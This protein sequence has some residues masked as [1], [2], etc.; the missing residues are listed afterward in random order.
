[1]TGEVTGKKRFVDRDVLNANQ[2]LVLLDGN[3]P[4]YHYE[5][6]TM[7]KHVENSP[8]VQLRF[9]GQYESLGRAVLGPTGFLFRA[10]HFLVE[11]GSKLGIK[12]MTGTNRNDVSL[13]KFTKQGQVSHNIEYFVSHEFILKAQG[14]LG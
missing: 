1:M 14:F 7:G 2:D 10:V 4:V 9:V 3:Y 6:K 5:R 12:S 8:H 13:Q 11:L